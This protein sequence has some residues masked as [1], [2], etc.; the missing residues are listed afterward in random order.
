MIAIGCLAPLM[1]GAAGILAGNW[2]AGSGGA[3]W[4]GVLGLV[5]GGVILAAVGW[6]A[7]QLKS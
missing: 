5:F 1:L 6:V 7:R 3:I 4:G 2:L